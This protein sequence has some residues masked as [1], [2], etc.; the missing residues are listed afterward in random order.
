MRKEKGVAR[1]ISDSASLGQPNEARE[2]AGEFGRRSVLAREEEGGTVLSSKSNVAVLLLFTKA[3]V[4][5][6]LVRC[7]VVRDVQRQDE[8]K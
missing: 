4:D 5:T 7:H 8:C 2:R 3:N 6:K 1:G